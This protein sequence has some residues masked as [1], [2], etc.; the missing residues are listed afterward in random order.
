MKGN[1]QKVDFKNEKEALSYKLALIGKKYFGTLTFN[2]TDKTID[3]YQS[4]FLVIV[5]SGGVSQ[6]TLAK[7]IDVDK[8]TI[9]RMV[10]YLQEHDLVKRTAN[11]DDRREHIVVPTEKAQHVARCMAEDYI[12]V[13][14]W[15]FKDFSKT[16]RELFY[17]MLE[18][19]YQNLQPHK[20]DQYSVHYQK[21]TDKNKDEK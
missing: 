9:V 7:M 21:A 5:K 16:E 14:D 17:N 8:S 1:S 3:R 18:R 10:D 19:I 11:P 12:K 15:A 13:N 6:Q 2:A 20:S 4:I